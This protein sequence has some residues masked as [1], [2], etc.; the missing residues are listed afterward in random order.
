[1][2]GANHNNFCLNSFVH[3]KCSTV[4]LWLSNHLA[5]LGNAMSGRMY[6][7]Y[8]FMSQINR[9]VSVGFS[10]NQND[11]ENNA[12]SSIVVSNVNSNVKTISD[13]DARIDM[14]TV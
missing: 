1:M 7:E 12:V 11:E 10:D 6:S 9:S 4:K 8:F 5:V 14:L 2:G 3:C 13:V